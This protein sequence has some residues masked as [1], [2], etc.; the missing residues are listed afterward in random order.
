METP[1]DKDTK[2]SR[3]PGPVGRGATLQT[4]NRFERV[5]ADSSHESLE[6]LLDDETG[7]VI[8]P[9]PKTQ[10]IPD[11]ARSVLTRND[12]PDVG[13]DVSVNPYRGCEHGCAY[14][15]ARPTHEYLGYSAGLDFETRILVKHEAPRLLRDALMAKAWVPETINFSGVTDCYQPAERRFE[16]TR[17]CL[18]VAREFLNPVSIITKNHLVTRD[19]DLLKDLAAAKAA[20]VFVSVTTL[21]AE[22]CGVLEPRTSRPRMRLRAIE[23]LSAAG[24]PVGVMVAPCIPGLTDHEMPAILSAARNSGAQWAGYVPVRLPLAVRPI[25]EAWLEAHRPDRKDKVLHRIQELRG[26]KAGGEAGARLNDSRFGH[27]MRGQG[28]FAEQIRALFK[29][30]CRKEGLNEREIEL[31][32]AAFRRP[33][34]QLGFF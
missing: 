22:L 33:G 32:T 15:Y 34:E 20:F 2:P 18:E 23:E 3:K 27:R 19:I 7:E 26:A 14:C 5:H 4:P 28:V 29:L 10:F 25:F 1:K 8:E 6:P 13:F 17:G 24:I 30:C 9:S 21:D 11:A 12:S 16:L 31:S